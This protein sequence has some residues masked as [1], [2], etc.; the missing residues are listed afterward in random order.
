MHRLD[1][2]VLFAHLAA[3]T[4]RLR[5]AT[6]IYVLP[7]VQPFITA[8]AIATADALS[9]GRMIFGIG[10]GWCR[11]EY[12]ILGEDFATRGRRADEILV[13]LRKLW[14]E[15]TIE[16]DGRYYKFPP[17]EFEPKPTQRPHPPIIYGGHSPRAIARAAT[18]DGL[19]LTAN[20]P[21]TSTGLDEVMPAIVE[22]QRLRREAGRSDEPFDITLSTPIPTTVD[23]LKQLEEIGV[24]RVLFEIGQSPLTNPPTDIELTPDGVRRNLDQVADALLGKL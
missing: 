1:P 14:N 20:A 9:N 24:T 16:H 22:V 21:L 15:K 5:F 12:E 23:A 6:G 11:E 3:V 4:T 19:F 13:V 18:L 8:R 2:W 10:V 7:L 17:L